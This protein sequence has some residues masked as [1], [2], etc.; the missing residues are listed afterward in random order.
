MSPDAMYLLDRIGIVVLGTHV[1]M[2]P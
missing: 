2:M 1:N